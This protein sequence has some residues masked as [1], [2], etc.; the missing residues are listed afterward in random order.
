MNRTVKKLTIALCMVTAVGLTGC[1]NVPAS[2]SGAARQSAS[3][4]AEFTPAQQQEISE[5]VAKTLINNPSILVQSVQ[6][7]KQQQ[8]QVVNQQAINAIVSNAGAL[9]ADSGSPSIGDPNAPVTVIEFFD[10]Q[11]AYCHQA[12]PTV[13][14]ILSQ[15]P[16]VRVVFKELPIFGGASTYAAE[17]SLAAF[18]QDKFEVFHDALFNSGL[19]EG[20]LTKKDVD[21]IAQESGID[22]S[23]AKTF[24]TSAEAQ[25]ELSQNQTLASQ[26]GAQGTPDFVVMPTTKTPDQT[27]VSFL[28]GAVPLQALSQAIQTASNS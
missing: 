21:R 20:Q 24:I 15:Y 27:K 11:C 28:P 2:N 9:V 13:Q 19:M 7:L 12:F 5:I 14:S 26:L 22:L 6:A 10:Y 8:T 17:M 3:Q 4:A 18:N 25:N 16:N 1:A 23:A